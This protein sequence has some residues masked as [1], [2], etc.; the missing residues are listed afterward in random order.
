MHG[1]FIK[2]LLL[3][4]A[5]LYII[6]SLTWW[7]KLSSKPVLVYI[8]PGSSAYD[9]SI[10]LKQA[11]V[12]NSSKMF[13]LTAKI[14]RSI[15]QLKSGTYEISPRDSIFKVIAMLEKG[16]SKY[17]KV[18]IPEG[19]TCRQIA[20]KLSELGIA[21][22]DK[23]IKLTKDENLE[24]YL[25][26][27]TYY[28]ERNIPEQKLVNKMLEQ[29]NVH[30]SSDMRKRANSMKYMNEKNII[31][32]ASII[33]KEAALEAERPVISAVFHNRL[34]KYMYLESCATVL[35][36]MGI[37]KDKLTYDDLKIDSPYNT[38]K[39]YGLPPGPIC[40]PGLGSINAALY[41]ADST[42]LYFVARGSG[43]HSFSVG[44][45][46]H[47]KEKRKAKKHGK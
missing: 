3:S 41:P 47:L 34:K 25:F 31:I 10:K 40:N 37:H 5:V 15:K 43:T 35:Y 17:I 33:E 6:G 44:Y 12:I 1:R 36:A 46:E 24:G 8:P 27:E 4:L 20:D 7:M 22:K 9:I 42:D 13:L 39:H 32:L 11:G 18:T 23:F 28:L 26:P 29:F 16:K 45:K 38:Y 14:T 21:D 2:Y 30:F 19:F